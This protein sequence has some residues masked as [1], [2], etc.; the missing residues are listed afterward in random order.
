MIWTVKELVGFSKGTTT[1]ING[2]WVPARP[3]NYRNI[4][5]IIK[6]VYM[7]ILGKADVVVWS[8]GRKDNR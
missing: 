2:K 8:Y 6:E 4:K 1:E 5:N 7:I 3:L